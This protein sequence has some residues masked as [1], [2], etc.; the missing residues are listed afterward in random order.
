M[1]TRNFL[2]GAAA[3]LALV[4]TGCSKPAP[5]D[6][7]PEAQGYLML[8]GK[9]AKEQAGAARFMKVLEK[10]SPEANTSTDADKVYVAFDAA[11][12]SQPSMY[13]VL[14]G[15]AGMADKVIAEAKK[16]GAVDAT[17]DGEAAVTMKQ[18]DQTAY[19][20]KVGE[21][22]V[23]AA[24]SEADFRKMAATAKRKNPA[25]VNSALFG[26]TTGKAGSHVLVATFNTGS[27]MQQ[28]APQLGLLAM[29]NPKGAEAAKKVERLTVTADW[30]EQPQ[31]VVQMGMSE[32]A[33]ANDL[34]SLINMGL[35][36]LLSQ[37]NA[38]Q[39]PDF[40]KNLK[41][42]T[43]EEGVKL[44]VIVPKEMGESFLAFVEETAKS[45]PADPKARESMLM[46]LLQNMGGE[47]G[48]PQSAPDSTTPSDSMPTEPVTPAPP[49]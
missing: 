22:A 10:I 40:V 13:G 48:A 43:D 1:M 20:V 14:T 9:T 2:M 46:D 28:V 32:T 15:K 42:E 49:M 8:N 45:M 34:A 16:Q 29:I 41:A 38:A 35:Q 31:M 47:P 5:L 6:Y 36:Q 12:G 39:M 44:E 30:A 25:A 26:K 33:D 7:L 27:L 21:D 37:P 4:M 18:G 23:V 3:G 24:G 11:P 19:L 17:V